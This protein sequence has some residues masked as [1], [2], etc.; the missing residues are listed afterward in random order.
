MD[1]QQLQWNFLFI[2]KLKK[3]R[4]NYRREKEKIRQKF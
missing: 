2:K 1:R 4:N 3:P